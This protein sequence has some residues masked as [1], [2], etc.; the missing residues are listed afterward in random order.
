MSAALAMV[1]SMIALPERYDIA[2]GANASMLTVTLAGRSG[3]SI[4]LMASRFWG[5]LLGGAWPRRCRGVVPAEP[6]A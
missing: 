6:L 4:P 2:C 5:T 1:V 3:H